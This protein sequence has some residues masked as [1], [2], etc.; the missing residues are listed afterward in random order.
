MLNPNSDSSI[1]T[2]KEVYE[3]AGKENLWV[4]IEEIGS[5]TFNLE[6]IPILLQK[7]QSTDAAD[8]HFAAI[9]LRKITHDDQSIEK[10]V[11]DCNILPRLT[12]FLEKEEFPCLQFET[13]WALSNLF[14]FYPYIMKKVSQKGGIWT[15][16]RLLKSKH[17]DIAIQVI[18]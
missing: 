7:A 4:F 16:V 5:R 12:E 9:G 8:Q 2:F 13:I 3:Q 18:N 14:Q 11:E 17:P 10:V 6:E 15:I 1:S